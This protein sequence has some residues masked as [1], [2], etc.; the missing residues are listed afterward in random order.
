MAEEYQYED[1]DPEDIAKLLSQC[2]DALED[3]ANWRYLHSPIDAKLKG[4]WNEAEELWNDLHQAYDPDEEELGYINSQFMDEL[5]NDC[6]IDDDKIVALYKFM[7]QY[8]RE[9]VEYVVDETITLPSYNTIYI[10][11]T[12][13]THLIA[14]SSLVN[15]DISSLHTYLH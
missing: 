3:N 1:K 14:P 10:I 6:D 12:F 9:E 8:L 2:W 13:I 7:M 5:K 15:I 11:Y 4:D